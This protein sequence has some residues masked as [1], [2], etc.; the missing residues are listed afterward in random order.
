ME[1]T[2]KLKC[3]LDQ[4]RL[5]DPDNEIKI[6]QSWER[7]TDALGENELETISFLRSCS[8]E[9]LNLVSEVFD[10][11]ADRLQSKAFIALLRELDKKYPDLKLTYFID[12]AEGYLK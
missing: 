8:K 11:V 1:F 10:D 7:L 6:K 9:D 2:A 3:I 5:I 12:D 4:R